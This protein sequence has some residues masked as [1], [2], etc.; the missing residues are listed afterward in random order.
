[1]PQYRSILE[2]AGDLVL[3]T[4]ALKQFLICF[5]MKNRGM[6]TEIRNFGKVLEQQ[7]T[8]CES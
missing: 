3:L 6:S 7:K 1:M 4:L 5:N 2:P 8:S